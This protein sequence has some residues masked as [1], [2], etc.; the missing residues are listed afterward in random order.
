[1]FSVA[2]ILNAETHRYGWDPSARKIGDLNGDGVDD[3]LVVMDGGEC[4]CT[5]SQK[6]SS[7]V[8]GGAVIVLGRRDIGDEQMIN[9][10]SAGRAHFSSAYSLCRAASGSACGGSKWRRPA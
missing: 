5:A 7:E 6:G 9:S 8:V 10:E 3:L 2:N 4:I 1:M